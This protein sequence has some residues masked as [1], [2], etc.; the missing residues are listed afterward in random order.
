MEGIH[1]GNGKLL[2]SLIRWTKT[3]VP[4]EQQEKYLK[5]QR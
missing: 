5:N 4:F 3:Q 1:M 2:A